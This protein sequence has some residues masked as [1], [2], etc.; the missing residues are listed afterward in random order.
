M[1]FMC[2]TNMK[3]LLSFVDDPFE[4]VFHMRWK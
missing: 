3:I 2:Y 1:V 4:R